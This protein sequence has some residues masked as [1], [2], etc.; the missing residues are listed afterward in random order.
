M[1]YSIYMK[2]LLSVM[3]FDNK[4]IKFGGSVPFRIDTLVRFVIFEIIIMPDY[5]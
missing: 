4:N 1:Y 3:R 2:T 5:F